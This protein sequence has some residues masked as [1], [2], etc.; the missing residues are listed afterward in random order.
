MTA[1]STLILAAALAAF[2]RAPRRLPFE[3]LAAGLLALLLCAAQV[4][5]TWELVRASVGQYRSDWL[6]GG[7]GMPLASLVSL[8]HPNRYGLF[9]PATFRSSYELTH[10]YLFSGWS[11][12]LL[13]LLAFWRLRDPAWRALAATGAVSFALMFG[14][15]TPLG[16]YLF[17]ALPGALRNTVYWYLFCAPFLL[18]L[19]L[20]AG[21]GAEVWLRRDRWRYA[22]ALLL[23]A[24]CILVS[25]GRPM[26][27]AVKAS[28]PLFTAASFDGSAQ[29]LTRIRDAA[30]GGRVDTV[31]YAL[32][33]MTGAPVMRLRVANGY[34]PLA[35]ERL[36]QVRLQMAK[37]ERW[38]AYYQVENPNSPAL[39]ALGVRAL[40]TRST[41]SE[42]SRWKLDA[43][44]PGARV[45]VNPDAPPRYRLVG[46]VRPG[47]VVQPGVTVAEG[48]QLQGG[49]GGTVRVLTETRQHVELE[50]ESTGPSYLATSEAHYPGWSARV[51][52]RPANI[53]YTNIAFR[54]VPLPAGRH[55][56][57]FE[58]HSPTAR[59]G[60]VVSV[61]ALL[62]WAA[63]AGRAFKLTYRT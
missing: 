7:G 23:T 42:T 45:Y 52:G 5:P 55:R 34:D 29:A 17:R 57:Q 62:L 54:G 43:E 19:S 50:T 11:G 16:V 1:A 46:E 35:L 3:V 10:L 25:S 32:H 31:D 61:L 59:T 9:D 36:I 40:V 4:L 49:A 12:L 48:F 20:L 21:R 44:I 51:D 41:L 2:G 26:N 47:A 30:A 63:L 22:V 39:D 37:G 28:E 18:A 38:G 56:V 14:E 6:T 24:E 15:F 53:Y 33:L 8:V 58:F 27:T 13:S 60:V